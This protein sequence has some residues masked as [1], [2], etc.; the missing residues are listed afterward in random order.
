MNISSQSK[1]TLEYNNQNENSNYTYAM[2]AISS[3]A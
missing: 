1:Y 2:F 3:F